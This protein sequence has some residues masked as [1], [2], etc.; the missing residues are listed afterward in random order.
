M[1]VFYLKHPV[2]GAKVATS[3]QEVAYDAKSGWVEFDPTASVEPIN[4]F[5]KPAA[6]RR[7]PKVE[8]ALNGDSV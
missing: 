2:H 6:R 3:V 5:A 7:A 8:P 1:G 4:V